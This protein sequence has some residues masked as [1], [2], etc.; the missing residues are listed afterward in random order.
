MPLNTTIKKLTIYAGNKKNA[1]ILKQAKEDVEGTCKT[2]KIDISSEEGEGKTVP[3][4]PNVRFSAQ[5]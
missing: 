2:E 3:E 4:Y 1:Q 5:Y